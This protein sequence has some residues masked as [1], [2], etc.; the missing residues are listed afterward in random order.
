[1]SRELSELKLKNSIAF[2][3]GSKVE[4]KH[5]IGS[6]VVRVVD[7]YMHVCTHLVEFEGIGNKIWVSPI[8]FFKG[9]I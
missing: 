6:G 7:N 2:P 4:L 3:V 9:V 8:Q 1:M 5:D